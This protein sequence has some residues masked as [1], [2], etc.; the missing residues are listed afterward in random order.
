[1]TMALLSASGSSLRSD[2][3]GFPLYSIKTV[4]WS[5][6]C[7]SFKRVCAARAGRDWISVWW[8]DEAPG[9]LVRGFVLGWGLGVPDDASRE[10]P[11]H[12]HSH[13]IRGLGTCPLSRSLSLSTKH[14]T[15]VSNI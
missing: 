9:V 15:L 5:F 6:G 14:V 8:P 1:M 3:S 13:V 7:N 11:A 4:G 2:L 12:L 10:L